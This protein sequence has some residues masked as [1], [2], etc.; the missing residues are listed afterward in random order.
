MPLGGL[1]DEIDVK[2]YRSHVKIPLIFVVPAAFLVTLYAAAY[3]Y[4]NS[5]WFLESLT[6]TLHEELSGKFRVEELLVEPTMTRVHLYDAEV[7]TAED[8]PVIEADEVYARLEP[9]VLLTRRIS[10]AE[11]RAVGAHVRLEFDDEGRIGLLRAL[12]VTYDDDEPEDDDESG[13]LSVEFADIE[14][15]DSRFTFTRP[16]FR[17]SIPSVDIPHGSIAIEPEALLMHVPELQVPQI[18]FVFEPEL[19]RLPDEYGDWEFS[20]R[21][22]DIHNWRWAN[23][24]F[25]VDQINVMVEGASLEARG[26][27]AF[28]EDDGPEP[29][30]M[31]YEG[32]A[33]VSVPYWSPLA[34]YFLKDRVHFEL[35]E[36]HG[37]VRGTL[38]EVEV[39]AQAFASRVETAGLHYRNIAATLT[40][41][42]QWIEVLEAQG[43][44]HGGRVDVKDG[45]F[46]MFSLAYGANGTFEGVDPRSL[47]QDL[48]VDLPFLEGRA[49]GGFSVEGGVPSYPEV[50]AEEPYLLR[51]YADRKYAEVVATEDWVLERTSRELVPAASAVLQEGTSTW[52]DMDRV[53]VPRSR[54]RLDRDRVLLEDFRFQYHD[55]IFEEGPDGEPVALD[56]TIADIGPWAA[57]YGLDGLQG[58][59][60]VRATVAGPL[61]S[62]E[63]TFDMRNRGGPLRVGVDDLDADDMRLRFALRQGRLSIDEASVST[64][65]GSAN[66]SGWIDLLE[67]TATG[68][69]KGESTFA[70]RSLQ[71]ADLEVS[72]ADVDLSEVAKMAGVPV[73][74]RG[75][76]SASGKLAG[77]LQKPRGGA[78]ARIEGGEVLEQPLP[79]VALKAALEEG[80]VVLDRL[81][82]DA[83]GAG[84]FMASGRYGFDQS[85]EFSLD[86]TDISFSQ[87]KPLEHVPAAARPRGRA[88]ISLHGEGTLDEP[89]LGGDLQIYELRVGDRPLGDVALVVNTVDGTVY[90]L[91]G[92]QPLATL[93]AEVP[94]D[95]ESP[96]YA[97]VGMEQLDLSQAIGELE[98][99][100]V[101][102]RAMV[103]GM[104]ELF[105][106][107]DLSRYQLVSY[108][109]DVEVG[110]L[111]R[112]IKNRGPLVFG[113]NDAGVLQVQQA[114][115]GT[116]DR[117]LDL[118]G[119]VV[120]D[121]LLVDVAFDGQVDLS[122][123]NTARR[124]FPAYFPPTFIE[125]HG[126]LE[127]DASFQG[128]PDNLVADGK[129]AVDGAEVALRGL[130]D[131]VRVGSG[132]VHLERD[133]VYITDDDPISG[134]ALGGVFSLAGDMSLEGQRPG[135][136]D[137]RAWS[138]NMNI[139]LPDAANLTFDTDL[140]L[141]ARDLQ[142]PETWLVSG[143][144]DV[145]DGLFYRDI[146]LF[147]QEVAGRV[148]GAFDRRTERYEAS[149]FDQ[150]PQLE[151]I[152][153]DLAL[154]ARDG[155]QIRNQIDRLSLDLELRVDVR[156][157]QTLLE[158]NVTGDVEVAAG[159]VTFQG[160]EFDV[161]SGTVRFAGDAKR[162]WIDLVAG[163]DIRNRCR[164]DQLLEDFQTDMT[165]S[166]NLSE[167]EERYYHVLLNLR[168]NADNLDIQ[169]ESNP[170]ADQ[171]DILSLLL[172]GCTVDQLTASSASGPT[173]EVALG[174]LLGRIEKEIQDV[175]KVSE[176]TIMPGVERTQVRIGDRL[177]RRLSW[178]F[179]LDTGFADTAGGQRYQLEYKL[180]DRWSAELSERSQNETNNLLLDLK[181][182]YRLP[183]D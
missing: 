59:M 30:V 130:P 20:V 125:S 177:T 38:N 85:Y 124:A 42:D 91:G 87:I 45:Y 168:G 176:F 22:I 105:V 24:G 65:L 120:F 76:L 69:P 134:S 154:R 121:P 52:V 183:L 128:S 145:L 13:S 122:V 6:S 32:S 113:L 17:F 182:K 43:D 16:N 143:Q 40:L 19:M 142:Q 164:G 129:L 79:H 175:V 54:I 101:I 7:T 8:E 28:P 109:T 2:V 178:N 71:P 3:L 132:S 68:R 172:T 53:V 67:P 14:V 127:I 55:F 64:R 15:A 99:S 47:L 163:A 26:Q 12:G 93:R 31:V 49:S 75:T 153:F 89:G 110:S 165:L 147:E 148:L 156:L 146:S 74:V 141:E 95:A 66:A 39:A 108:L 169:F 139:R 18:D 131:P 140:R 78:E 170:Y 173:L 84:K 104:V 167:T 100:P 151:D 88:R 162:P 81:E 50:S 58:P 149:L 51:D 133:R 9:L 137:V 46:N 136:L 57:L 77:S 180:S 41:R 27:M 90:V 155:F 97:R 159:A 34:Q 70:L 126:L 44:V 56:A 123:L 36:L 174:P 116:G 152:R 179:Q 29:P 158:P 107:K 10:V 98:D 115:V 73:P 112:T 33:S 119:A 11:G 161:R 135:Q 114:T 80:G 83:A 157:Q 171:R 103:T 86:G 48:K 96:F 5:G 106:E 181:L 111:G 166:G 150:I 102:S 25:I 117:Y 62:P 94:L 72:V 61:A 23:D 138:H 1:T 63:F 160:E 144:V 21:D 118:E 60:D 37:S 82:I 4:A 92:A 35:D